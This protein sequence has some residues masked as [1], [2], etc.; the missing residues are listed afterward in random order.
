[1][2]KHQQEK[3]MWRL[4]LVM[5][6]IAS[7]VVT[8]ILMVASLVMG[9]DGGYHLIMVSVLGFLAAIPASYAVAYKINE[10]HR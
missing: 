2:S 1:M 6:L 4:G 10:N 5:Y 7:T 3:I 9:R 8:G